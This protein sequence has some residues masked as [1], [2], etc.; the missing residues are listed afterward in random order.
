MGRTLFALSSH[1]AR[2]RWPPLPR[3]PSFPPLRAPRGSGQP[4]ARAG[5]LPFSWPV[6]ESTTSSQATTEAT[7][8]SESRAAS[9]RRNFHPTAA[10]LPLDVPRSCPPVFHLA[11]SL[12]PAH[13]KEKKNS[14]ALPCYKRRHR[15]HHSFLLPAWAR[16]RHRIYAHWS[17]ASRQGHTTLNIAEPED[18]GCVCGHDGPWAR[19]RTCSIR[20]TR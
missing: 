17:T 3:L 18:S 11:R 4:D 20:A 13:K 6:R 7:S 10:R 5:G 1:V 8:R 15:R 16:P 14:V 12:L 9:T 2:L 19:A